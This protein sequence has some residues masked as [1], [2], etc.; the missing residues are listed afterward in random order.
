MCQFWDSDIAISISDV[1]AGS[2]IVL[3]LL[4]AFPDSC[5][6]LLGGFVVCFWTPMYTSVLDS[7]CTLLNAST[8]IQSLFYSAS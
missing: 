2:A 7:S 4:E 8:A 6:S 1:V 3:A 5:F